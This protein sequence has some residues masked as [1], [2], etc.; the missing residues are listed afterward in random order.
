MSGAIYCYKVLPDNRVL[1]VGA[2]QDLLTDTQ[3]R[4]ER[5]YPRFG[6]HK[7]QDAD[8]TMNLFLQPNDTEAEDWYAKA[9]SEDFIEIYYY[10][11]LDNDPNPRTFF[12]VFRLF[13]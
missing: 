8:H 10:D 6:K 12:M 1:R 4:F 5:L 3:D 11:P 2:M 7:I 9:Y 13:D